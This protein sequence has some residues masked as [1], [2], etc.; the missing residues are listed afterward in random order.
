ME[1]I[2]PNQEEAVRACREFC[3]HL[4]DLQE[5][6]GVTM[7]SD[8]SSSMEFIQADYY[9]AEGKVRTYTFY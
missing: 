1:K 2:Y 3:K 9:D 6:Y 8:D 7:T 5:K 4:Q